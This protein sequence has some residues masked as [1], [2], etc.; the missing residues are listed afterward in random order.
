MIMNGSSF[1]SPK[2]YLFAINLKN[3]IVALLRYTIIVQT[4]TGGHI[5][6]Y[7]QFLAKNFDL[8]QKKLDWV[9]K[10]LISRLKALT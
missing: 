3:S 8:V 9:Q 1:A 4:Y 6:L 5:S 7:R 10:G 2:P